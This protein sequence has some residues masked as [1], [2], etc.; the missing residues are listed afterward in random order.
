MTLHIMYTSGH[1][2]IICIYWAFWG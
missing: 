2:I 1:N